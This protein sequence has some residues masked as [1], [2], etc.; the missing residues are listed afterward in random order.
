[1]YFSH[2]NGPIK[3]QNQSTM[4][5][6][7]CNSLC[8]ESIWSA[9][10]TKLALA[11]H[12]FHGQIHFNSMMQFK[13]ATGPPGVCMDTA[14]HTYKN[15]NSKGKWNQRRPSSTPTRPQPMYWKMPPVSARRLAHVWPKHGGCNNWFTDFAAKPQIAPSEFIPVT[16][17]TSH[18][19]CTKTT[20]SY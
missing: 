5:V 15:A 13:S 3:S 2:L 11:Y 6:V 12:C 9:S 17:S 10:L 8:W 18:F 1:M 7:L 20:R 16:K 14:N 19:R 4:Y